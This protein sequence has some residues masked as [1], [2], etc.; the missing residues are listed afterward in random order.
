MLRFLALLIFGLLLP[1]L[2]LAAVFT[3]PLYKGVRHSQVE[4]LQ[5][6]LK[7]SPDIYPEGLVTGHFGNLTEMAVK[8]FQAKY[9]IA[10]VDANGMLVRFKEKPAAEENLT[11]ATEEMCWQSRI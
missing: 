8:R 9:G 6:F 1:S 2:L 7:Q 11:Y 3:E 10:Q 5:K 4:E